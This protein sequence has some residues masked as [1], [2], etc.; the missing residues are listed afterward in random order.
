MSNYD[1]DMKVILRNTYFG[2]IPLLVREI[3]FR[4]IVLSTFYLSTNI[5]H[6]PILRYSVPEIMHYM[7]QRREAGYNDSIHDIKAVIYDH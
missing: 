1:I 7:K 3:S 5:E 6:K 2:F 4:A